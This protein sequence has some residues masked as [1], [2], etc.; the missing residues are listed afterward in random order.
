MYGQRYDQAGTP[1]GDQFRINADPVFGS[2]NDFGRVTM[3]EPGSF[4]AAWWG[5]GGILG[6]ALSVDGSPLT[7]DFQ[8]NTYTTGS[9]NFPSPSGAADGTF[10]VVWA[11]Y[12]DGDLTGIFGQRLALPQI[13]TDGFESGDSSAWSSTVQ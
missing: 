5:S 3:V 7:D 4:V 1:V 8:V 2:Y 9:Q 11:S 12:H 13:F 10:V 6:R